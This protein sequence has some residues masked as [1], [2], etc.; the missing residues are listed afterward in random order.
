[1][2][3]VSYR[4]TVLVD[5]DLRGR[6]DDYITFRISYLNLAHRVAKEKFLR[7]ELVYYC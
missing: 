5:D 1:M 4:I 6:R 7:Q 3:N 2:S